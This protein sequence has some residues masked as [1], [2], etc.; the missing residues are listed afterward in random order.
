MSREQVLD[1]ADSVARRDGIEGLTVRSLS[2]ELGVTAPALYRHF[3]AKELVVDEVVDRIIGRTELPGPEVGDWAERLR[4]CFVSVHDQVA[5][6]AGLAGRM[7]HQ[8]PKSQSADRNGAYLDAVLGEAGVDEV[9]A[10]RIIFA[11]F[12]YTWGHLLA[13]EAMGGDGEGD[14]AEDSSRQQFLWGLDHLLDSFRQ[15][16][17]LRPRRTRR[18]T[19]STAARGTHVSRPRPARRIR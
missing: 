10:S 2:R 7:A 3:P 18:A 11:V 8:L 13:A 6:Y 14:P 17:R 1:A 15:E 12:V 5:P 9:N 19:K 16:L 4:I